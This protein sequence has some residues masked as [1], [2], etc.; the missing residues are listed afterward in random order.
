M[1]AL[2][3]AALAQAK[4][5]PLPPG[6]D[7]GGVAV[8]LLTTGIDY[9][10]PEVARRLARDGEGELIGFDLV[11]NDNRPFGDR[12]AE[13]PAHWGGDATALAASLL[14]PIVD[15]RLVPMRVNPH[16]PASFA[17]AVAFVVRTPARIIAVP[18]WS[19][20]KE[21]WQHFRQ[22]AE[23]SPQVL[24]IAAA[25]DD[26]R[27]LDQHPAYPAALGL[28]NLLVVAA[29]SSDGDSPLSARLLA[30]ANRGAKTVDAVAVAA[31]SAFATAIAA[32]AAA[33]LLAREQGLAG[34]ALKERLLE[35]SLLKRE[36]ETPQLTRTLAVLAASVLKPTR[37]ARDP[38]GRVLDKARI[39][40]RLQEPGP[41]G[42]QPRD[43][44]KR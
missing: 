8:A 35:V 20:S 1:L 2:G 25:G 34:A 28:S 44:S 5:P 19:G 41:Q 22:A 7:P 4:K 17:R 21:D 43:G 32:K 3:P 6:L 33:T 27:D 39:P 18:M 40:E 13:T 29:A 23:R 16:D 36:G 26:G 9:T 10:V 15:T 30:T 31:N 11:D 24:F 37:G 42:P 38:A 12:R 14:D